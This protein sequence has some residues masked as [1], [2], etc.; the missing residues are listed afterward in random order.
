MNFTPMENI[1][2]NIMNGLRGPLW[3]VPIDLDSKKVGQ[4]RQWLNEKPADRLVTN[5]DI[6]YFLRK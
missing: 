5:E 2:E 6:I 3:K 4:L 1:K